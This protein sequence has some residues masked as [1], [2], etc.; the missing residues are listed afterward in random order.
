MIK[1][2]E[3][4]EVLERLRIAR[5][6]LGITQA[7]FARRIGLTQTSMSMI[8][9]GKSNLTDK[10]IK[11]ICVTYN[12]NEAWLLTETGG[13]FVSPSPYEK[14]LLEIFR[15]LYDAYQEFL[16]ETTKNLLKRQN[17]ARTADA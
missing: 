13:M 3:C 14:E 12:I 6:K 9:S 4:K 8:Q 1:T 5:K 7:E 16:L 11:L 10:N 2:E 15:K 17:P